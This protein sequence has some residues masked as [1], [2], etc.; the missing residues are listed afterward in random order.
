MDST[1]IIEYLHRNGASTYGDLA[2]AVVPFRHKA[3]DLHGYFAWSEVDNAVA[4]FIKNGLIRY[5]AAGKL[6]LVPP[7]PT[8]AQP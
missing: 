1:K 3:S 6:E 8:A 4:R 5:N 2:H 7:P